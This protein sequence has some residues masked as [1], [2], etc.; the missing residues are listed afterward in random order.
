MLEHT[1]RDIWHVLFYHYW[2][3]S[4]SVSIIHFPELWFWCNW[5]SRTSE[6]STALNYDV[7]SWPLDSVLGI[8][9]EYLVC[10]LYHTEPNVP[11]DACSLTDNIIISTHALASPTPPIVFN[12][13]Y[14]QDS[15]CRKLCLKYL[16][17]LYH[18]LHSQFLITLYRLCNKE[19]VLKHCTNFL[20]NPSPK[21]K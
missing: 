20:S 12:S 17:L 15:I 3:L 4:S 8:V 16:Y 11:L 2:W 6:S 9:V 14:M 10:I 13:N 18:Q 7:A 1:V 19:M 21:L 5:F